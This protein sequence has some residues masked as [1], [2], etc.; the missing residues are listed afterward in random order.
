[1]IDIFSSCNSCPEAKLNYQIS[2]VKQDFMFK[3]ELL[4][5]LQEETD[6][7]PR[8]ILPT[9]LTPTTTHMVIHTFVSLSGE[10]EYIWCHIFK[11]KLNLIRSSSTNASIVVALHTLGDEERVDC[12][13]DLLLIL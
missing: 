9:G 13:S 4:E 11:T 1:M 10:V 8:L 5:K 2:V 6:R 3:G 12:A 7:M